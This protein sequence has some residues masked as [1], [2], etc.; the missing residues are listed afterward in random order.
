MDKRLGERIWAY[1]SNLKYMFFLMLSAVAGYGFFLVNTSISADDLTQSRY[2]NGE[3]FRQGRFTSSVLNRL[4]S[5]TDTSAYITDVFGLLCLI[6]AS[7]VFCCIFDRLLKK[8]SLFARTAFS[9]LLVTAPIF[10]EIITYKGCFF[11]TGGGMLISA[12]SLWLMFDYLENKKIQNIVYSALLLMIVASWYESLLVVYFGGVFA[13]LILKA[14]NTKETIKFKDF[15]ICGLIFA[16]P[17]IIGVFAE[18]IFQG[19]IKNI[20]DISDSHIT[21]NQVKLFDKEKSTLISLIANLGYQLVLRGMW[22]FPVTMLVIAFGIGAVNCIFLTYNKKSLP[23]F[24]GFAGLFLSNI[25]LAIISW[26]WVKLRTQQ[27][28]AFF[29]AFNIFLFIHIIESCDKKALLKKIVKAATVYLVILQITTLNYWTN[30]DYVRYMEEKTVVEQV[31]YTINQNFDTE[32]P[33]VFIGNYELS[34]YIKDK[35]Y[36]KNDSMLV[37]LLKKPMNAVGA[38]NFINTDEKYALKM[39]GSICDSY[40]NWGIRAFN[41]DDEYANTELHKFFS[42]HGFNFKQASMEIFD[43]EEPLYESMPRWPKK[44]SIVEKDDCIVVNF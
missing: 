1:I 14:L 9:C 35:T 6:L 33:V 29:I 23:V 8:T 25:I 41:T 43:R 31:A 34:D 30:I 19:A 27:V 3:L 4:L 32:K 13:V 2:I 42:Y 18:F 10:L 38:G 5:T 40:I 17:L 12:V 28:S 20:F 44:G 11:S 24:L 7:I 15:V 36:L 39:Q 21:T 37:K 26:G 22:Y 16:I